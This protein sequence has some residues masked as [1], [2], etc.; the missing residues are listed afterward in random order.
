MKERVLNALQNLTNQVA[1]ADPLKKEIAVALKVEEEQISKMAG[2]LLRSILHQYGDF[3]IGTIDSFMHRVVR[4]FAYDLHLPVSFSVE[5]KKENLLDQAIDQILDLAG[6]DKAITDVLFAFNKSQSDNEK[7]TDIRNDLSA[8]AK[9]LLD[10]VKATMVTKLAGL[11]I[12]HFLQLEKTLKENCRKHVSEMQALGIALT[13][14]IEEHAIDIADLVRG[15]TGIYSLWKKAAT[16]DDLSKIEI[17]AT[18]RSNLENGT[19]T[20]SKCSRNGREKIEAIVPELEALTYKLVDFIDTVKGTYII[21]RECYNSIHTMA[22]LNEIANRIELIRTN[23]HTLHISEFNRRVAEIVMNEPAPFVYERL[24]EKYYNYLIDEFQDTS[25]TQWQNLLPLVQNGLA[26]ASRSLLVG[27]GKQAIYRFRGGDVEQF[28]TLPEPYPDNLNDTQRERYNLLKLHYDELPLT[29]NYRSSPTIVNWNNAFYQHLA[30]RLQPQHAALYSN[31]NQLSDPN[32]EIGLVSIRFL[33]TTGENSID[34]DEIQADE[35]LRLVNELIN[36]RNYAPSDIAILTRKNDKGALLANT[37]LENNIPVISGES[38]LV[39][40]K[41]EVQF[42]L[43]WLRVLSNS[44]VQVNLLHICGFLIQ[45]R[46]LPLEGIDALIKCVA[47][48]EEAVVK[49]LEEAGFNINLPLLKAQNLAEVVHLLC[50]E[51]K[52]SII[53]DSFLQFFLEAVWFLSDQSNPDIHAFLEKWADMENEYSVALPQSADAVRI[54]SVHKSKGLEFPVVILAYAINEKNKPSF[55]WIDDANALPKGIPAMRFRVKKGFG[56]SAIEGYM[57]DEISRQTL[58]KLNLLYV[59]TTR[60]K[61][62]L[63]ILSQPVKDFSTDGWGSFLQDFCS[64]HAPSEDG[65]WNWG[66]VVH[67]K[68]KAETATENQAQS[69][70]AYEIGNWRVKLA[71]SKSRSATFENDAI[72]LGNLMHTTLSWIHKA[73]DFDAA[74]LRLKNSGLTSQQE[75][76]IVG[77]RIEQL[78]ANKKIKP[79]FTTFDSAFIERSILCSNGEVLRPDRVVRHG[80]TSTIVEYKSGAQNDKHKKQIKQYLETL[81]EM[82]SGEEIRALLVYLGETVVLEEVA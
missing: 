31:L 67:F 76:E 77:M 34:T 30:N 64:T 72:R 46:M 25:I 56:N 13:D 27:D 21:E 5:L 60:P 14:L 49:M 17:S 44:D 18:T 11:P 73:S 41:P 37:L 71:M 66:D 40:G 28:I 61:K 35:V 22:L 68:K 39:K 1:H 9:D 82:Q 53:G 70:P 24:G 50:R 23:E 8:I 38:L 32:R 6:E 65:S 74:M 78:L 7:S 33:D 75:Q 16:S 80:N 48:N 63:Y 55:M 10:D 79:L 69:T 81:R 19:W 54:M 62:A 20:S 29:T 2:N 43:A 58:D 57:A 45:R 15:S 12:E 47:I 52:F 42:I 36:E 59:A 51:F 4:T 26:T 3:S